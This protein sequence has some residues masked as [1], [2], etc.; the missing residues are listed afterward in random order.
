MGADTVE[1]SQLNGGAWDFTTTPAVIATMH[2]AKTYL[3]GNKDTEISVHIM[4]P[5]ESQQLQRM[6]REGQVEDVTDAIR[7]RK[8][9]RFLR[10]DLATIKG[11]L[12]ARKDEGDEE[13]ASMCEQ[14]APFMFAEYTDIFNRARKG[15]LDFEM[16]GTFVDVLEK[17]EKGELG[18]H[19]GAHVIGK[20]LKKVYIDAALRQ[21]EKLDEEKSAADSGVAPPA[22]PRKI[23]YRAFSGRNLLSN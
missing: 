6:I 16:M 3:I 18:Q 21:A 5:D 4:N 11:L 12:E 8:H 20:L 10:M 1:A 7:K 13:F 23:S 19:D 2:I 22:S 9:S 17:I 14:R 15:N